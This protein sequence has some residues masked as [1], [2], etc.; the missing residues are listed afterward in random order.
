MSYK[1]VVDI[2]IK[3]SKREEKFIK[4]NKV[5]LFQILLEN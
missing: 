2:P 4:I 1:V 5:L 3:N